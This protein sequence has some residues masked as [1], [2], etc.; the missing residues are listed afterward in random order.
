MKIF[1]IKKGKTI[2]FIDKSNLHYALREAG[3]DIDYHRLYDFLK[4]ELPEGFETYYYEGYFPDKTPGL[5]PLR[6]E[7]GKELSETRKQRKFRFFEK[8]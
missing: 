1:K 5:S 3:W 2:V 8:L 4:S 7:N 6:D